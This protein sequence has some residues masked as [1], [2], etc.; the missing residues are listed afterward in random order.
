MKKLIEDKKIAIIIMFIMIVTAT[1]FGS[2]R[3]LNKM[4][5]EVNNVFYDGIHQDGDSIANDLSTRVDAAN[6][7]ITIADKYNENIPS[8]LISDVR[9]AIETLSNA[10]K[11][12]AKYTAN[13]LL[14]STTD[15]LILY[16]ESSSTISQKDTE[17]MIGFKATLVSRSNTI[18][19]DPYNQM[20]EEYNQVLESF[21]ANLLSKI[22]GI[23][24][25]ESFE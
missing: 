25:A 19:R 16:L 20:V 11:L 1:L 24:Q 7:L 18:A 2:Y 6:N 12:S 21:P 8:S 9:E 23:K 17:Y 13:Q 14:T 3:S 5:Q 10:T 22:T 15:S 4:Y